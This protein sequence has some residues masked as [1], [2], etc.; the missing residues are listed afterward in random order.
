MKNIDPNFLTHLEGGATTICRLWLIKRSDGQE[1]GF[2]DHDQLINFEGVNFEASSGMDAQAIQSTGGLAVNNSAAIGAL[3]SAGITEEDI[4]VGK[5]DDAEVFHW[6]VNWNDTT[7]NNLLFRGYLADIKRDGSAFEV[8]LRGLTEKI[9]QPVGRNYA[10]TCAHVL[11]NGKCGI[12]LNGPLFSGTATVTAITSE[13]QFE[14]SGLAGFENEWFSSGTIKWLSGA[15]ADALSVLNQDKVLDGIHSLSIW[16]KTTKPISIGD[17]LTVYAGCDR[18]AK[19]CVKKFANMMNFG[20]FPYL[21]GEDWAVAY[22]VKTNS[23]DG[24][25]LYGGFDDE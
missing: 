4:A 9:N 22:P 21:P 11:G 24:E 19:T 23:L 20:G 2:T 25:S 3:N 1:L 13:A 10:R 15:N 5:Y 8:E 14:V 16:E 7:Q 6:L 12:D 17:T 18:S